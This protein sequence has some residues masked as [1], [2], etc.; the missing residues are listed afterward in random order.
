MFVSDIY[1]ARLRYLS[2]SSQISISCK[3]DITKNNNRYVA[4]L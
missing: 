3:L 1:H 4:I 2:R